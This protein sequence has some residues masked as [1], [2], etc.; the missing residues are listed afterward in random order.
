MQYRV[1]EPGEVLLAGG[2]VLNVVD[3]TDVYMTFLL[4]TE[5]AGRV[6]LGAEVRLN[7][8]GILALGCMSP[9]W[10]LSRPSPGRARWT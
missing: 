5:Q 3:L 4:P 8:R 10:R 9:A 1:T 2:V 7:G 6:A